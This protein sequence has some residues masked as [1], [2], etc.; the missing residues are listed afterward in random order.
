MTN[1]LNANGQGAKYTYMQISI[2]YC[3]RRC[4]LYV[5]TSL[6]ISK[7]ADKSY[8]KKHLCKIVIFFTRLTSSFVSSIFC[9]NLLKYQQS[10]N[11][12]DNNEA[13]S[14]LRFYVQKIAISLKQRL[15][16]TSNFRNIDLIILFIKQQVFMSLSAYK[17]KLKE[18]LI[19]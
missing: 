4:D 17:N 13:N 5:H 11:K 7:N 9:L 3:V 14:K 6:S 2:V 16:D 10:D 1:E 12:Q 19:I 8:W 18:Y 15:N